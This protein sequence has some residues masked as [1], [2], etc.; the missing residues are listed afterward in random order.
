[1]HRASERGSGSLSYREREH[2]VWPSSSWKLY[3]PFAQK[4][5]ETG[6]TDSNKKLAKVPVLLKYNG[7]IGE[8]IY[9]LVKLLCTC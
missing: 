6:L 8:Y 5:D 4:E 1:M 2:G 3:L 9:Q 7:S